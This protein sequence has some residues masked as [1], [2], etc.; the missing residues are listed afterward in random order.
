MSHIV[1][2]CRMK[3]TKAKHRLGVSVML[4]AETARGDTEQPAPRRK[5]ARG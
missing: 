1:R 2:R 4:D 3:G 5:K